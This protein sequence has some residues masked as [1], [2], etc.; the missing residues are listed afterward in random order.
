M[1]GQA[2]E[3]PE[4]QQVVGEDG[5]GQPN[6]APGGLQPFDVIK[7]ERGDDHL[8]RRAR[9]GGNG[10]RHDQRDEQANQRNKIAEI[11]HPDFLLVL[12]LTLPDVARLGANGLAQVAHPVNAG[13]KGNQQTD[14][15]DGGTLL[16][17]GIDGAFERAGKGRVTDVIQDLSEDILQQRRVRREHKTGCRKRHHQDW[18][19]RQEGKIGDGGTKLV[20]HAVIKPFCGAYQVRN[21]GKLLN[22]RGDAGD[23]PQRF[24][25]GAWRFG[26]F[27]PGF[28]LFDG[29]IL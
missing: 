24:A 23:G 26:L 16:N 17:G 1:A 27:G 5:N 12:R 13:V 15:A 18:D 20:P 25:G 8:L 4:E 3:D 21:H 14:D 10:K 7:V 2:P 9:H 11:L 28:H 19:H 29:L 6:A 22:S